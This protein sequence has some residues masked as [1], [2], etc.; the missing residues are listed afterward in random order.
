M[1]DSTNIAD[2]FV[3]MPFMWSFGVILGYVYAP[4]RSGIETDSFRRPLMGGLLSS[5]A[6]KWPSVFGRFAIFRDLPYFL[7]CAAAGVVAFVIYLIAF[8]ALN[9]V[10]NPSLFQR[11]H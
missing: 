8:I 3:Y 4:A 11:H 10:S 7:P 5:P 9:E 6:T 1:T 2:V